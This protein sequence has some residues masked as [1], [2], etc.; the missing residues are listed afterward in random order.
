MKTWVGLRDGS[1]SEGVFF[2]IQ[3]NG[4]PVAERRMLPGGW[5]SLEVDLSPWRGKPI[6][7]SLIVDSDGDFSF[8]WAVWGDPRIERIH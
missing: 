3:V 8:D 2:G 6:V 5:E 1:K 4:Q 7:L